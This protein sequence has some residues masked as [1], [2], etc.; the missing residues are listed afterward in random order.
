MEAPRLSGAEKHVISEEN[1]STVILPLKK[2]TRI[3][4][5]K[6]AFYL[7]LLGFFCYCVWLTV[8]RLLPEGQAASVLSDFLLFQGF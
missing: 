8:H 1:R 3:R 6:T 4:P 5:L 2:K 7:F